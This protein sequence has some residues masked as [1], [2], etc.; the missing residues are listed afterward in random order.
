MNRHCST[1]PE[2][3][4]F[5]DT[6]PVEPAC[7]SIGQ[8]AEENCHCDLTIIWPGVSQFGEKMISRNSSTQIL[9]RTQLQAFSYYTAQSIAIFFNMDEVFTSRTSIVGTPLTHVARARPQTDRRLCIASPLLSA[10]HFRS[11]DSGCWRRLERGTMF[12]TFPARNNVALLGQQITIPNHGREL[13]VRKQFQFRT[14]TKQ[15]QRTVQYSAIEPGPGDC[16]RFEEQLRDPT[17]GAPPGPTEV[18]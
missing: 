18:Q 15:L 12:T 2:T 4:T 16:T 9:V 3:T 7:V 13:R 14:Q 5:S 1:P 17:T 6:S 10:A 11:R 8:A